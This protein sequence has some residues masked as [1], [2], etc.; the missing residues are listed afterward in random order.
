MNEKRHARLW[1]ARARSCTGIACAMALEDA[2]LVRYLTCV[3]IQNHRAVAGARQH[4]GEQRRDGVG[5]GV[6]G[7]LTDTLSVEPVVFHETDDRRLIGRG[8]VNVVGPRPG[9]NHQQW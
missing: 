5:D 7:T 3:V 8:V 9:G 4:E 2:T 6:E 1:S